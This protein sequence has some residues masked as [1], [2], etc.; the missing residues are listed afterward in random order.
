MRSDRS[1]QRRRRSDRENR[2]QRIDELTAR[3]DALTLEQNRLRREIDSL[4]KEKN[5]ERVST[6]LRDRNNKILHIGDIVFVITQ[7]T[8]TVRFHGVDKAVVTGVSRNN[9]RVLLACFSDPTNTSNRES[10]NVRL[11]TEQDEER[12]RNDAKQ[13]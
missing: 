2:E 13:S 3:L 1:E 7:S 5:A 8:R 12:V 9:R 4:R 6:G 10:H 11:W